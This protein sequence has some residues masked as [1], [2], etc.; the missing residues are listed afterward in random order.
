MM[1]LVTRA[2][3][4]VRECRESQAGEEWGAEMAPAACVW[5]NSSLVG[6][7]ATG[8]RRFDDQDSNFQLGR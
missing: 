5:E 1:W 2:Q 8:R 7:R 3:V 4:V 6:H